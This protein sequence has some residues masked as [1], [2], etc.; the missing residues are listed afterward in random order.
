MKFSRTLEIS[1]DHEQLVVYTSGPYEISR[2]FA[3][4][5]EDKILRW[6]YEVLFEDFDS[7]RYPGRVRFTTVLGTTR[8]LADAK[9]MAREHAAEQ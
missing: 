1:N 3:V 7:D 8:F 9:K 6:D 2:N 4:R 5:E